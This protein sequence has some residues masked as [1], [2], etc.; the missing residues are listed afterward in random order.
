M[1]YVKENA[2]QGN[3]FQAGGITNPSGTS[4]GIAT[5]APRDADASVIRNIKKKGAA[6]G[7]VFR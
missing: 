7:P 1:R 6:D 5:L 3:W 4:P 2:Q